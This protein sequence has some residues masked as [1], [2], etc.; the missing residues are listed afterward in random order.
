[1][2]KYT[3]SASFYKFGRYNF[4][5]FGKKPM[6]YNIQY[7]YTYTF[8]STHN[9]NFDIISVKGSHVSRNLQYN[10]KAR[11]YN[12]NMPHWYDVKDYTELHSYCARRSRGKFGDDYVLFA[13]K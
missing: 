10:T 13:K 7:G 11:T 8:P 1:M 2:R 5:K 6:V 9:K 3:T 12:M 4:V